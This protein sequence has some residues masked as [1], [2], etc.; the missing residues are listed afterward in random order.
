MFES[1]AV[2]QP[3]SDVR[4]RSDDQMRLENRIR[5]CHVDICFPARRLLKGQSANCN[6]QHSIPEKEISVRT[7]VRASMTGSHRHAHCMCLG[8]YTTNRCAC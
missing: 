4:I 7:A 5:R 2:F 8:R 3:G 6:L 1:G